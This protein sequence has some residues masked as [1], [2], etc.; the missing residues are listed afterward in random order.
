[1]RL[2][3]FDENKDFV[4]DD[5]VTLILGDNIVYGHNFPNMLKDANARGGATVFAYPR[6]GGV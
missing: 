1:M 5:P 4:G 2:F 3:G 6:K